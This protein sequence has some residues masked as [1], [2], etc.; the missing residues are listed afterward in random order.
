MKKQLMVIMPFTLEVWDILM[1]NYIPLVHLVFGYVESCFLFDP[2]SLA[3]NMTNLLKIS[4]SIIFNLIIKNTIYSNQ[5]YHYKWLFLFSF[6]IFFKS[7]WRC[8][9]LV[10]RILRLC[11]HK[12]DS[13]EMLSI[14]LVEK[15]Y[16][17][18]QT[19]SR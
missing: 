17:Y 6:L 2:T 10:L 4:H 19:F 15:G 12:R 7:Y 14:D 11:S 3:E 13:D 16:Y 9:Q 5:C 8:D 18:N 1:W